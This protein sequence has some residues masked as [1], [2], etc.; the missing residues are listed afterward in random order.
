M[1]KIV[2]FNIDNIIDLFKLD[3]LSLCQHAIKNWTDIK[4]TFVRLGLL[5]L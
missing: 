1:G 2:D 3:L 4:E 5:I